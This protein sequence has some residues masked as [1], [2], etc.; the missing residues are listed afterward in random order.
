[1][2]RLTLFRLTRGEAAFSCKAFVGAM[3]AMYVASLAGIPR[4]FWAMLTSYIVAAPFAGHVRSK[5]LFRLLG[6]ALGCIATLLFLP[7]LLAA[8]ELATL[9]IA[10]WVGLCLYLS[11]RDRSA[12]SYTF[13]LAGYTATLI[14]FSTVEVPLSM[15]D[16]ASSRVEEI[17]IGIVCATLVHSIVFPVG[18]APTVL[19]YLDRSLADAAKWLEALI[20]SDAMR[21]NSERLSSDHQRLANDLTQLRL[22]VVHIPFDTSHLRW[23]A[24]EVGSAQDSLTALVPVLL[25]FED[26]LQALL[27]EEGQLAP[28][29]SEL[30]A[31][32]SQW[33]G[34]DDV[35]QRRLAA[36]RLSKALS[37]L[38][39]EG[40]LPV[41]GIAWSQA[42][43]FRLSVRLQEWMRGWQASLDARESV[44]KGLLGFSIA[45]SRKPSQGIRPLHRDKGLALLS[46]IAT[47]LAICISCAFWIA[48]AW[49]VGGLATIYAAVFSCLF[50]TFDDPALPIVRFMKFTLVSAPISCFYALVLLPLVSD[51]G[52]FAVVCFPFLFLLGCWY[53]RPETAM[54]ATAVLIGVVGTLSMHD[55]SNVVDI[56]SVVNSIA[57]QVVGLGT[58]TIVTQIVRSVGAEW[59]SDRI[60]RASAREIA[61]IATAPPGRA[62]PVDEFSVRALDRLS[63]VASRIGPSD[64]Q[65]RER[66][67]ADAMNDLC[68]GADAISLNHLRA[69]RS[70]AID[71]VMRTLYRHYRERGSGAEAPI[72]ANLLDELDQALNVTLP[73][74][75]RTD[76]GKEGRIAQAAL[77]GL[78]RNLFANVPVRR[79]VGLVDALRSTDGL[80]PNRSQ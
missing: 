43:R 19:G 56:A 10:A 38:G 13:M 54:P 69:M 12:R 36:E 44:R 11:L 58:A 17:A 51:F 23:A 3:L 59:S 77:A 28:D 18:L 42:L 41:Q 20:G 30:I 64:V 25:A 21:P 39:S 70:G 73:D 80:L 65:A 31:L 57:A 71:T 6:T 14:G 8:P 74:S 35:A 1:M 78:R 7:P 24:D 5:A 52:D 45:G 68:V 55:T 47:M 16:I 66:A 40:R 4:P 63:L 76:A 79:P 29:V 22:L 53:G 33:H 46:S 50:A 60:R 27:D 34:A 2:N 48:S 75:L 61:M 72:P 49:P 62:V 26:C 37:T 15:F 67:I 32:L 9:A